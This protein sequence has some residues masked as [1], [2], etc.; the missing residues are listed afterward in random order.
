MI[1]V[2]DQHVF[3]LVCVRACVAIE[4]THFRVR[5]DERLWISEVPSG[6]YSNSDTL[7]N[8]L[9]SEGGYEH[10]IHGSF[11]KT[12][13][14]RSLWDD[15]ESA[16]D[17]A[18][19]GECRVLR[20]IRSWQWC[21]LTKMKSSHE[22]GLKWPRMIWKSVLALSVPWRGYKW[23]FLD[24]TCGMTDSRDQTHAQRVTE[25]IMS[26]SFSTVNKRRKKK[27]ELVMLHPEKKITQCT[28]HSVIWC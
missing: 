7:L 24:C 3:W 4:T 6:N 2:S 10:H 12:E 21:V 18:L 20:C 15:V 17:N 16:W 5:R 27:E 9:M 28:V 26:N 14:L 13:S 22:Q 19:L 25:T 1:S 11:A 8:I 23:Q